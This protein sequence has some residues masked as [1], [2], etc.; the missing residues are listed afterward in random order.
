[1]AVHGHTKNFQG[2]ARFQ[3]NWFFF[4]FQSIQNKALHLEIQLAL[5]ILLVW[6]LKIIKKNGQ[7]VY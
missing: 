5:S 1:M 6:I 4:F 7:K 2:V 3:N